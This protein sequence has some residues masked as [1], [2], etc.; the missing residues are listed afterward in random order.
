MDL[1]LE[2]TASLEQRLV[3]RLGGLRREFALGERRLA[4]LDQERSS[5]Q[6]MMLRIAGAIELLEAELEPP[7][8]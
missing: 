3:A 1:P 5:L 2:H 8:R 4:A 7:P 6:A